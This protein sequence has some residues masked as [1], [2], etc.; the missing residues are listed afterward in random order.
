MEPQHIDEILERLPVQ[1]SFKGTKTRTKSE[2]ADEANINNIVKRCMNGAAMPTGSRTPL[3]G[4]FSDVADFT[5]AQTLIAQANAEFEQLPSDVREKF[6][7]NVS[8]LMDFLDDENNLAEAI[9]LGLAPK[10]ESEPKTI[11]ENTQKAAPEP[12]LSESEVS[13]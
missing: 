9:E 6:G 7:N 3:F 12:T 8:D 4:D 11:D 10:P 5:S 13:G 2:F 1:I